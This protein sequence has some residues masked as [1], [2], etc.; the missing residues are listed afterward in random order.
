MSKANV[1]VIA[2]EGLTTN[3]L[4]E[5][6]SH[7]VNVTQV[8]IETPESKKAIL[9]RR[10][11]RI[12]LSKTIGQVLFMLFALPFV[13][14]K[15]KRISQIMKDHNLKGNEIDPNLIQ[16]IDSVHDNAF[17]QQLETAQPTL[18]FINGTRILKKALLE[19]IKCPIINIHVGITPKYRG[20]HGGYWAVHNNDLAHFGVTLHLVDAGIDTGQIIA[21]KVIIPAKDDNFKTYPILQYCNGL[22]LISSQHEN[23][24]SDKIKTTAAITQES[25]L[26]FHPTLWQ[27]W[28]KGKS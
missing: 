17:A 10:I 2:S 3:L 20:V 7:R 16:Q 11:K 15:E 9:K 18:I 27:F 1:V 24:L 21:Q 5:H 14:K 13:P 6:L 12:G 28:F 8:F 19:K 4:V 23:L 22:D 25:K 26:H